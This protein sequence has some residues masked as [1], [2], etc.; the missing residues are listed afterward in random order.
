MSPIYL[1]AL[2]FLRSAITGFCFRQF[3]LRASQVGLVRNALE[4]FLRLLF[5]GQ[6]GGFVKLFAAQRGVREHGHEVRLDLQ[7]AARDVEK[8]LLALHVFDANFA[9]SVPAALSPG[10][11][12]N[13]PVIGALSYG[14]GYLMVA[15]DGGIFSFSDK[16]FHGSLGANPPTNPIVGVAI[17]KA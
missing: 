14:N 10:Q 11:R 15:S 6:R 9:G 4:R 17:W 1:L 3:G 16:P 12:L 2:E 7:H 8:V 5:R 13:K